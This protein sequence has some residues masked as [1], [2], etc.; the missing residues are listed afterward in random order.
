MQNKKR[1]PEQTRQKII[2]AAVARVLKQGYA[3]T[4]IDQIC[5]DSGVTK[6]SFFHHF[7][8]KEAMARSAVKCWS[9]YGTS[10]CAK[11]WEDSTQDPLDQLRMMMGI[12][13]GFAKRP[14]EPCV[15]VVGM[16]AQEL[17]TSNPEMRDACGQELALWTANVERLLT[18][19]KK[20]HPV[21]I[22]FNP[23]EVAWFLNSLWQGSML[24]A[25]TVQAQPIIVANLQ[26]ARSY[27]ESL[28]ELSRKE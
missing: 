25:K 20:L 14:D 15:C 8:S 10:L 11:A 4:T 7:E 22:D 27:V 3:A 6:G 17:S 23:R 1:N 21:K 12:M 28:F 26:M 16:L 13:E 24:V 19:A 2:E 5:E 9:E 18:E